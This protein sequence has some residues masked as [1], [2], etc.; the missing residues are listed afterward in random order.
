MYIVK[1]TMTMAC[2]IGTNL[3]RTNSVEVT[4]NLHSKGFFLHLNDAENDPTYFYIL[5]R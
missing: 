4:F 2:I 3:F 1:Y 5:L